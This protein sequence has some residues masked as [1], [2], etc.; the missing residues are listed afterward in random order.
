MGYVIG[1]MSSTLTGPRH[2][3]QWSSKF[4]RKPVGS[5][6]GG[7]LYALSAMADHMSLLRHYYGAF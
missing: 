1:L 5:S 3:L 2:V 6:L 4:T 7:E